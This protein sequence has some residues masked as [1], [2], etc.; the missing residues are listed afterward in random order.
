VE[1]CFSKSSIYLDKIFLFLIELLKLLKMSAK[2]FSN[3][4]MGIDLGKSH[5]RFEALAKRG[6]KKFVLDR[7]TL[8]VEDK[9]YITG[10]KF[11][12]IFIHIRDLVLKI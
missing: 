7:L 4:L 8:G 6:V 5:K 10:C 3:I 9:V 2:N 11:L 1:I 12:Y